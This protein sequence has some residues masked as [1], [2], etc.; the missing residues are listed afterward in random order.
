METVSRRHLNVQAWLQARVGQSG[1]GTAFCPS[2]SVFPRQSHSTVAVHTH[3][4]SGDEQQAAWW[5][6][7]TDIV[8]PQ[9]L[10]HLQF[11]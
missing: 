11:P 2:S 6:Q 8:P 9:Q 3:L 5:L 1:T 10:Y 7:L 4:P